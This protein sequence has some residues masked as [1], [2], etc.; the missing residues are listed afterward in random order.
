MSKFTYIGEKPIASNHA[1]N[2]ARLDIDLILEQKYGKSLLN[3]NQISYKD[4]LEK[5]KWVLSLKNIKLLIE[6]SSIK[7][8]KMI[9]QYPFYFNTILR[10]ILGTLSKSNKE[11]LIVHDVDSLRVIG[12]QSLGEDIADMNRA[13]V[14]ILHNQKMIDALRSIGLKIPAVNLELF[15]YLLD[16]ELP[17][18]NYELGKIIAFA[19]NLEK[20]TFLKNNSFENLNLD[21]NLYGPNFD[22]EKI[23]WENITYKGS[24]KPDEIPYKLEGSFGLIWDGEVLDT[25]SGAFGQYMKYN[26]PH[27]LSLYIAS[28]LPVVV[29]EEAAIAD[30]VKKYD[31][32]ITVKSLFDIES[33]INLLTCKQ[34]DIF[35][36]NILKLQQRVANGYYTKRAL[37]ECENILAEK[38]ISNVKK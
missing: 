5:I 1:G 8:Q 20:S 7:K 32:G 34:Y 15:D 4:I 23:C 11:I 33:K 19:G 12:N 2:K 27:K 16:G 38:G 37:D 29:W 22:K 17:K 18:H 3:I 35:K 14:V 30:F 13:V 36:Q 25:C 31:I 9:L 6:L 10:K 26:N 21:F 28:G 24:F